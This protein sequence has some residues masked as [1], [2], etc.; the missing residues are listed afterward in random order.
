MGT[1]DFSV[2]ALDA[3]HAAGHEIACVYTRAPR[4]AGRGQ[5]ERPSPVHAR[6]A[7]LGL[8]VRT[9]RSLRDRRR[10]GRLRRASR[11][12]PPSS[13]PTASSCRNPCSTPP[14]ADASTSTPRSCHAGAAPPRSSAR[15]WPAT[16]RP[17]SPS[18]RWRPASTPARSCFAP[19]PPIGPRDTAGTLHDRLA[20]LGARLIVDALAHLDGLPPLPQPADGVTYAA[21]ID[22][23][24][25]RVDWTRPATE[26]DRLVRGLSPFP[27]AWTEAGGERL[28]LL[29]S[30]TGPRHR[31]S[32]NGARRRRRPSPA[33]KARCASSACS[34]PAAGRRTRPGSSAVSPSLPATASA[35]VAFPARPA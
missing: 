13:S 17:A 14:R 19:P 33:A 28:K 3:L 12:R 21:K 5:K 20:A 27:G 10:A 24:E 9:P 8:A 15:S 7:A 16:P 31:R 1:P 18:W 30:E 4:P 23:A 34:A 2:P 25:A 32:R 22:K 26:V 35:E 6:A 29:L 11:R